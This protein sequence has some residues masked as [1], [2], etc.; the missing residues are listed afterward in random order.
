MIYWRLTFL[1][2]QLTYLFYYHVLKG[3]LHVYCVILH[4]Q[5]EQKQAPILYVLVPVNDILLPFSNFTEAKK[6]P[7][8]SEYL[9][10]VVNQVDLFFPHF[11]YNQRLPQ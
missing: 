10:P 9:H 7:S 1:L 3:I 2:L 8:S 6:H 4:F 11:Q 5:G